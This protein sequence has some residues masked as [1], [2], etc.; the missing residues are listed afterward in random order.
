[1]LMIPAGSETSS[2]GIASCIYNILANSDVMQR[3]SEEIRSKYRSEEEITFEAVAEMKYLDACINEAFRLYPP[4]AIFNP[5]VVGAPGG[6]DVMG[7]H[8]PYKVRKKYSL[9]SLLPT[10]PR[11]PS[12]SSSHS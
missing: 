6:C 12:I 10:A 9:S 4:I 3:L 8:V 1:M 11:V 5:R 7:A 2:A